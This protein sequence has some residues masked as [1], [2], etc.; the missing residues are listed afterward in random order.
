MKRRTPRCGALIEREA[1][2]LSRHLFGDEPAYHTLLAVPTP[3]DA[4]KYFTDPNTTG[5]YEHRMR[6]LIAR[7]IGESLQHEFVHLMHYGH[8]ERLRQKHPIWIQEGIAALFEAYELDSAGSITFLP[9]TRHNI[10]YRAVDSN[11]AL[12][13]PKLFAL[14]PEA[15]MERSAGL[16]P[17]ARSIFLYLADRGKLTD[18]YQAYTDGF[19]TDPS[20]AKAL[21]KVFGK[22]LGD[23]ERQWRNWVKS[24]GPIDDTVRAGDAS[25]GIAIT[26]TP[27]GIRIKETLKGSAVRAAGMRVGDVIVAIDGK[28]IRSSRELAVAIASKRVGDTIAVRFRRDDD[29]QETPV[30]LRPLQPASRSR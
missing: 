2:W 19:R 9:N 22:P 27:G 13:W 1:D 3:S 10:I 20:G 7:D 4:K 8:M 30:T 16:Y 11:A 6:M 28:P 18:W 26:E 5:I 29:Y 23:I 12:D 17:E 21:E 15:F 24:K 14:S 25:L